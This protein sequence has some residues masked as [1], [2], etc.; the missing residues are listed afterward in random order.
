MAA[1]RSRNTKPEL[2]L[3]RALRDAGL[4]GYRCNH[5]HLPGRPDIAFTRWRV[6]V[7]VDGA[8]WHGHPDFF[9]FGRHGEYWDDKIRRTQVR[10]AVQEQ[11][12]VEA[13]Y[14]VVRFWDHNVVEDPSACVSKIVA[15]LAEAGSPAALAER[16]PPQAVSI[17]QTS[18]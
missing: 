15:V 4:V 16:P 18:S 2:M 11:A 14:A 17:P 6:A 9:V 1:I 12:L 10:D 5:P 7:F 13:G 8:F 3:R